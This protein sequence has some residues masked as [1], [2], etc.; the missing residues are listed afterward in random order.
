MQNKTS[1][2]EVICKYLEF[3]KIL[4]DLLRIYF[5]QAVFYSLV[6]VQRKPS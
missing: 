5:L 1:L 6:W 3:V 2:V 4:L